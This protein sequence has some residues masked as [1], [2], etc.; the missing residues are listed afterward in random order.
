M[1][2]QAY[3]S[4]LSE[5]MGVLAVIM[6]LG[7]SPAFQRAPLGFRY[8]RR[9]VGVSISLFTLLFVIAFQYYASVGALSAPDL[10]RGPYFAAGALDSL[11]RALILA[12]IGLA[13]FIVALVL[14]G[15]PLRSIG[16]GRA[17]LGAAVRMG[18]AVAIIVIFLRGKGPNII[19]GLSTQ[20]GM[21]LLYWL[22]LALAEETIF[23][24]YLQPRLSSL[25]GARWGWLA[26]AGLSTLWYLPGR[27]D[28]LGT[29]NLLIGLALAAVQGLLLGFMMK[30]AQHVAAPALLRA[31][32]GWLAMVV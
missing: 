24:G 16:W 19:D 4:T 5:W 13:V 3:V 17:G 21:A 6:L 20:E 2:I 28:G 30:K 25:L 7:I 15:Q 26:A 31:V 14:R 27:L 23:R 10:P 18:L 22:G 9:E 12:A 29:Q 11:Q 32:S 8:A 1:G